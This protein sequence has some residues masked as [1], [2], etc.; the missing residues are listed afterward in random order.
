MDKEPTIPIKKAESGV[1]L[2]KGA[3]EK[4]GPT[5]YGQAKWRAKYGIPY[6]QEINDLINNENKG[7]KIYENLGI[8]YYLLPIF[9]MRYKGTDKA[10][11]KYIEEEKISQV[12]ELAAGLSPEGMVL[13]DA[14]PELKYIET[15][16]PEMTEIKKEIVGK[17][18]QKKENLNL[19]SAN[20][21]DF[22]Q[23]EKV[24]ENLDP[25]KKV[26][27]TNTGLLIYLKPS[28]RKNLMDNIQKI[29]KKFGGV[30]ITP[31]PSM[32]NER[33]RLMHAWRNSQQAIEGEVKQ[34][35]ERN[36]Q[37]NS[38]ENEKATDDFYAQA[39]FKIKKLSQ[40]D[41]GEELAS[42]DLIEDKNEREYII[43]NIQEYGKV[44]VFSL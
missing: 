29:L 31:D 42:I 9:E 40:M 11:R 20:A 18:S 19:A 28:E 8:T 36:Y 21:L 4:I 2:E 14:Y 22:S 23:M 25:N 27:I 43:K 33:R 37:Q 39:G 32:H 6:A 24:L 10:I 17:V 16:L 7:L 34:A 30:W 38:L 3:Y 5:A 12:V 1:N 41:E 15:D 13:T 44:W 35:T 26:I